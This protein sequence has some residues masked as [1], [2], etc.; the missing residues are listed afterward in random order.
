MASLLVQLFSSDEIDILHDDLV[1]LMSH[2]DRCW[3]DIHCMR[4]AASL[5]PRTSVLGEELQSHRQRYRAMFRALFRRNANWEGTDEDILAAVGAEV[6]AEMAAAAPDA[7]R[8]AAKDLNRV[9]IREDDTD[10]PTCTI[11]LVTL[12]A[13]DECAILP[14]EHSY[15]PVCI[16]NWLDMD[17]RCPVC[18][19]ELPMENH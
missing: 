7:K 8:P 18:R 13:G 16:N 3:G 12:S 6:D 4:I 5:R 19:Y 1:Y 11:C 17:H 9:T 15:H 2:T 14:C 10:P